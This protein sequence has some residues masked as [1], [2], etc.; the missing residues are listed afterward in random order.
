MSSE[1]EQVQQ[2]KEEALVAQRAAEGALR[3]AKKQVE[4]QELVSLYSVMLMHW[5]ITFFLFPQSIALFQRKVKSLEDELAEAKSSMEESRA[6]EAQWR[7]IK[8]ET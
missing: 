2:V 8:Y 6:Q 1:V 5:C 7:A 3:D 4:A